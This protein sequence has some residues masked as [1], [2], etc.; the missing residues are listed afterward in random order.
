MLLARVRLRD[1]ARQCHVRMS[2]SNL[3]NNGTDRLD[4]LMTTHDLS[5]QP[6]TTHVNTFALGNLIWKAL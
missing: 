3:S 4:L 5:D 2:S 6:V 1:V